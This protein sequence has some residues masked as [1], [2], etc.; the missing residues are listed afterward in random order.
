MYLNRRFRNR[1]NLPISN[2]KPDLHNINAHTIDIYLS[3]HL[4]MK[5]WTDECMTNRW[6]D[7]HR[8]IHCETILP[9]RSIKMKI[10]FMMII[11]KACH[12]WLIF[13]SHTSYRCS[14]ILPQTSSCHLLVFNFYHD[15]LVIFSYFS[16]KTGFDISCKLSPLETIC[17]KCQNLFFGKNKKNISVCHLL[18]ILPRVLSIKSSRL[19]INC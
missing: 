12:Y 4:E 13:C 6:M 19:E 18:K 10:H 7:R 1:L 8:N 5:I 11:T 2:P 3:N 15:K 14:N 9:W 16:Q 17:M